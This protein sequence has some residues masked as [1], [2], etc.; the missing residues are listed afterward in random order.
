MRRLAAAIV[1]VVAIVGMRLYTR[2]S[3]HDDL[4][5]RL[6]ELCAGDAACQTAVH[7]HY[8]GCFEASYKGGASRHASRVDESSLIK[9]INSRAGEAY[10]FMRD[11]G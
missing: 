6:I 10:F 1:A 4:R 7:T 8:D 11:Q 5:S 3:T 2:T 9:C